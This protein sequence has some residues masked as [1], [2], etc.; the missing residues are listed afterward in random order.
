MLR[1]DLRRTATRNMVNR[2]IAERVAMSVT[3]HKTAAMFTRY[4]ITSEADLERAMER[5]GEY[6]ERRAQEKPQVVPLKKA[7]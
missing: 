4:N 5:V 2:G 1:H 3:G 7:S 6:V